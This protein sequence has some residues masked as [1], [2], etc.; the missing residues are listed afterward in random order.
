MLTRIEV[1]GF[2][3]LLG[4]EAEFGLFNCI[5]G[6]NAVGKSNVFDAIEFLSALADHALLE[7]PNLVRTTTKR[8]GDPR[9]LFWTDGSTRATAM[10]FAVEMIVPDRVEDDFGRVAE[11]STTYMRYELE[12]GY[13]EPSGLDT[14]G[15][16]VL[17]HEK[18][19]HLTRE[20]ARDRLRFDHSAKRFRGEILKGHPTG[21]HPFIYT[22]KD[23][24]GQVT[25]KVSQDQHGGRPSPSP[26]HS[27]KATI[28][29]S[30]ATT[31]YPTI[32]AA[33]REMQSWR[34]LALEPAAM[35]EPDEFWAPKRMAPN[36][37]HVAATLYSLANR[38]HD[39]A[40]PD[41]DAVYAEL[42]NRMSDLVQVRSV[43]VG[44]DDK[45]ELLTIELEGSSGGFLPARALSDGTLRF[46]ALA[47][48]DIDPNVRGV[49]CMEEPENGI[50][51]AR[52]EAM[53]DLVCG[54]AVA[55]SEAPSH[56]NPLRQ[57][58]VNTHSPGLVRFIH[59]RDPGGLLIAKL[60]SIRSPAGSPTH[61][62][63]LVPVIGTWRT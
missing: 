39:G 54:L 36:G 53:V 16:L 19:E 42:A 59:A 50:H 38:N 37:A 14:Q 26:A 44:R 51:P 11:P 30:A 24:Q 33:R 18:L 49:L 4:F 48:L 10:R 15:R 31:E 40:E 60:V 5:A 29:S 57:V 25:I 32:L 55:P 2:K 61:A 62:L 21:K 28:I 43:R 17:R 46:L 1:D 58:I 6:P 9:E 56:T 8:V 34:R 35:R 45:R 23:E 12:L 22:E 13:E 63:R 3:N 20:D 7:G 47:V 52:L 27:A 41:A